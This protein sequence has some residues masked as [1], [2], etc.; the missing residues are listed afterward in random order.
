VYSSF[1]VSRNFREKS[2]LYMLETLELFAGIG[3]NSYGLRGWAK[4]V[5]FV[6]ICENAQ[7]VLRANH[8]SVPIHED[9]KTF[10]PDRKYDLIT[11]GWPCTGFS[12]AG[13][14]TG[15]E[16]EASGL[17]TEIA[18][19]VGLAKPSLVFLENSHVLSKPENLHVVSESFDRLGYDLR[20]IDFKAFA[21][22]ALHGR[23]RWFGLAV[24][25]GFVGLA[26]ENDVESF[27]W[28][29]FDGTITDS[30]VPRQIPS[31]TRENKIALELLGNS[32]VP[33]Q[34]RLAFFKLYASSDEWTIPKRFE[35]SSIFPVKG[36][37]R[38]T[39]PMPLR[40]E[41]EITDASEPPSDNSKRTLPPLRG[42]YKITSW[43]TP[44]KW[45]GCGARNSI[46]SKR[47]V[48]LLTNQVHVTGPND[49]TRRTLSG[50]WVKWLMGYPEIYIL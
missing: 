46:I 19:I 37:T 39:F 21:V 29:T 47:S 4:P 22:G 42:N 6:E 35:F 13:S 28:K 23:H 2:R 17:F 36:L 1:F 5:Q 15:F 16:H 10:V 18:R 40:I 38:R 45:Y 50:S 25:R 33:D 7:K 44:A 11:A 30:E 43:A 8:P 49:S 48:Q 24:R 27:V 32:V 41:V 14:K 20:S 9:V 26:L 3:G 31:N 12:V 34:V